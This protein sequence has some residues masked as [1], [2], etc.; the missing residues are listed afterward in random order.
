MATAG[1]S[2]ISAVG[3]TTAL[4]VAV[5]A[6]GK[7]VVAGYTSAGTLRFCPG[8]LQP[9]GSPGHQLRWRRQADH[10]FWRY[11]LRLCRGDAG[12]RQDRGGGSHYTAANFALARYNADG[13]LDSDFD[14]DGRL[15]TDNAGF[16]DYASAI[17][18]QPYGQIVIAGTSGNGTD[19]DFAVVRYR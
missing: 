15:M 18:L 9:D 12:G 8:A 7:I 3:M 6:D 14:S 4:R 16:D 1:W 17:V 19:L 11:G 2:P 10:R 5:Q 13:S